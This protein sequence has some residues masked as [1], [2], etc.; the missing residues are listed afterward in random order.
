MRTTVT[1][2]PDVA[3]AIDRMRREEGLGVSAAVNRLARAALAAPKARRRFRQRTAD[4]GATVDVANV[5]EVLELIEGPE[6][7]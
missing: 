3:A 6:H 5:A 4:L 7:R 1:L 2:E